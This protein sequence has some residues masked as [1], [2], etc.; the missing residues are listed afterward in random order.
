MVGVDTA[1]RNYLLFCVLPV[2]IGAGLFDWR[3][4]RLTHIE[5]TSGTH[6]SILHA[7][8]MTEIGLPV[9]LALFFEVD[10]LVLLVIILMFF[11]HEATTYWDVAYADGLREVTPNE[12][13]AHSFLE[14]LP[15]MNASVLFC[16]HWDQMLALFHIGKEQPDFRLRPKKQKL[17]L[18]YTVGVLA[19]VG[20]FIGL[21]YAEE[22][23]RCYRH[24]HTLA[25]HRNASRKQAS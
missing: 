16:L 12:Q 1:A 2:W 4:H 11:T 13:H 25:S 9:L 3:R 15:F 18:G 7:L 21:P 8:M 5:E 14:V 17:P 20:A 10:S 19:A 22:L 24:D 6:E 23:W